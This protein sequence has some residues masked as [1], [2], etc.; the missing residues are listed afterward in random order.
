MHRDEGV[1]GSP[2][3]T[4]PFLERFCSTEK[5]SHSH[6][7]ESCDGRPDMPFLDFRSTSSAL[8]G[9]DEGS[10]DADTVSASF[11]PSSGS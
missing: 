7:S 3:V 5:A 10:K 2:R 11:E 6:G 1:G 8:Y 9:A 4:E